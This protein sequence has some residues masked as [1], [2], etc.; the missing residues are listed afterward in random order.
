[1]DEKKPFENGSVG[2]ISIPKLYTSEYSEIVDNATYKYSADRRRYQYESVDDNIVPLSVTEVNDQFNRVRGEQNE[3][4][5]FHMLHA[6]F[7]LKNSKQE[8]SDDCLILTNQYL[9]HPSTLKSYERDF[10]IVN[11]NAGYIMNLEAKSYLNKAR[12][13]NLKGGAKEQLRMSKEILQEG[14][15]GMINK[16]WRLVSAIF[17]TRI[18]P[19]V[20]I[21]HS[22]SRFVLT[23]QS[24]TLFKDLWKMMPSK[25]VRSAIPKEK[26]I[27]NFRYI[28]KT[29]IFN[30]GR[31]E[32]DII[33]KICSNI[34]KAGSARNVAFW[35]PEQMDILD[36]NE[37]RVLL[38][39][40]NST[41]KTILMLYQAKRLLLAK[42]K[43]VFLVY[44]HHVRERKSLLQMKIE[45]DF[46]EHVDDGT[47][48]VKQFNGNFQD[49]AKKFK[50]YKDC[51]LFVDELLILYDPRGQIN[52]WR[53]HIE[54]ILNLWDKQH[55][56]SKFLWI[57]VAGFDGKIPIGAF[58]E[59]QN[60]AFWIPHLTY[61]LRNAIQILTI[62]NAYQTNS[63]P[64][65]NLSDLDV[66]LP[67][68]KVKNNW[69][70]NIPDNITGTFGPITLT[71]QKASE[72][73]E[74][75]F[76]QIMKISER[77]NPCAMII[78][79]T[80]LSRNELKHLEASEALEFIDIIFKNANRPPPFIHS[81]LSVRFDEREIKDWMVRPAG[82][83]RDLVVDYATSHGC[84]NDIVI[85]LQRYGQIIPPNSLLRAKSILAILTFDDL[86]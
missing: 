62:V 6:Y 84:E 28:C 14:F 61:P 50:K 54:N 42:Q 8:K 72:A 51:H 73:I 77:E 46:Q 25:P 49:I 66:G 83:N 37:K 23:K 71:R 20:Y 29:L 32:E 47:L 56:A 4:D 48:K 80:E 86:I 24:P 64:D 34:D 27:D 36:K 17:C 63:N 26:W 57:A 79:A 74:A 39:S 16:D 13:N 22:C 15:G 33:S 21:C 11:L 43:V 5:V 52:A 65:H 85:F 59:A 82:R 40:S 7:K 75:A 30:G 19:E 1:M 67:G 9:V 60:H 70:L 3:K 53:P 68:N 69:F 76:D 45:A 44:Q 12:L 31:I 35:S 41:G 18:A 2:I 58:Y 38:L 78:I 81:Y 10:V 55:N